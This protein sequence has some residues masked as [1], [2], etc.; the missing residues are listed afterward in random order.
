MLH[1]SAL[2]ETLPQLYKGDGRHA[3]LLAAEYCP[4]IRF[5]LRS[6]EQAQRLSAA[7]ISLHSIFP[8]RIYCMAFEEGTQGSQR[9]W[10]D[11]VGSRASA[12]VRFRGS[13]TRT[14]A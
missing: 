2:V 1:G 14:R 9:V 3:A 12:D 11:I 5:L 8:C 13:G 4:H 10:L 7:D 6:E